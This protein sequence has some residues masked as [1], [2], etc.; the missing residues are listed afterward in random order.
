MNLI[1]NQCKFQ[2]VSYKNANQHYHLIDDDFFTSFF[3]E[4]QNERQQN[5]FFVMERYFKDDR[6]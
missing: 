5:V 2:C 4:F 6:Q 1:I 3:F